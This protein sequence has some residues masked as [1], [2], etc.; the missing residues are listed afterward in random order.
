MGLFKKTPAKPAKTAPAPGPIKSIQQ[1]KKDL[2]NALKETA[3]RPVKRR[4]V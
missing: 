2:E 3:S 4:S 1:H